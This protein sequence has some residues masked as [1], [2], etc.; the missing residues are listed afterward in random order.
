MSSPIP[1][2]AV[3]RAAE[4]MGS[5]AALARALNVTGQCVAYWCEGRRRLSAERAIEI[6][7]VLG[8]RVCRHELRPELFGPPATAETEA[9]A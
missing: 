5:R 4:L 1:N 6:E 9:T 8:G 3:A 2:P 7:R